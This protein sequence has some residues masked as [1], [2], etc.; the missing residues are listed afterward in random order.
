M[1]RFNVAC[2]AEDFEQ[3][4]AAISEIIFVVLGSQNKPYLP[5]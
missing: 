4:T 3:L 5:N 1:E 2:A